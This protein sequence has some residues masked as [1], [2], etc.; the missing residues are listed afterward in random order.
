MMIHASSCLAAFSKPCL[1]YEESIRSLQ[2]AEPLCKQSL[3]CN[4]WL[5][6]RLG[7]TTHD[8]FG[9]RAVRGLGLQSASAWRTY[10]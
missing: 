2:N 7:A 10:L 9:V 3:F 8:T 5:R 1:R 4:K 6:M